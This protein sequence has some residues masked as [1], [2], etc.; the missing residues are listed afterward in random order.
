MTFVAQRD[1][2]MSVLSYFVAH[3]KTAFDDY[4][5]DKEGGTLRTSRQNGGGLQN[6]FY[7]QQ[8]LDNLGSEKQRQQTQLDKQLNL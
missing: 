5:V 7:L 6:F 4:G 3:I 1:S 8:V 2:N